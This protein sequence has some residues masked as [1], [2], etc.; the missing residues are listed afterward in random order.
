MN[1]FQEDMMLFCENNNCSKLFS[2][3]TFYKMEKKRLNMRIKCHKNKIPSV[4]L[5]LERMH[6][7]EIRFSC[8]MN[9]QSFIEQISEWQKNDRGEIS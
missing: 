5:I 4:E 8:D 3:V 9:R 6:K 7:M 1:K 2:L